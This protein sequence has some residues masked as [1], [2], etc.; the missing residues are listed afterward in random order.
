MAEIPEMIL[1]PACCDGADEEVE[2]SG[3]SAW[4]GLTAEEGL[5]RREG[6]DWRWTSR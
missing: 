3:E 6:A 1:R 2:E 5:V 4:S